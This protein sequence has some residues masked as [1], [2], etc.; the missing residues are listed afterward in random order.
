MAWQVEAVERSLRSVNADAIPPITPVLCFVRGDWPLLSP[1]NSYRGV[2]LEGT[3]S[4][5]KAVANGQVLD[6]AEIDR[7]TR[8]LAA[9]FPAK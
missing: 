8:V 6:T 1:P 5:K 3:R 9:T 4:I 7:L 2:R